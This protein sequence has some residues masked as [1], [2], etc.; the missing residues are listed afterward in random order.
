MDNIKMDLPNEFLKKWLL[1]ANEGKVSAEDIEKEY[2]AFAKNLRLDL[3][4]GEIASG[5]EDIK[6]EYDDVLEVVKDEIR[7][8]F[9]PQAQG[10]DDFIA[11][12][13]KKQLDE[14]KDNAFRK[15]YNQAFGKAV[16]E[17]AKTKVEITH[18]PVKVD[19]FNEIAKKK[20]EGA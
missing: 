16:I 14:N 13:A 7:N 17:Y 9:G 6:V 8:Y 20:Y 5:T 2:D 18:K 4:K 12:M 19:E 1:A 3:I 15:Y 11:Q 10:M